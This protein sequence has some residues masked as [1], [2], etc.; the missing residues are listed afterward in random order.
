LILFLP[1]LTL[2]QSEESTNGRLGIKTSIHASLLTGT[3]LQNERP[4]FGYTAGAFYQYAINNKLGLHSEIVASF[5]GSNFK[6]DITDYSKVALFYLDVPILLSYK[7]G[8]DAKNQLAFGPYTSYLGLSSLYVG[9]QKKAEINDLDLKPI[10]FGTALYY[11][12]INKVTIFQV[13]VKIGL[14]NINNGLYIENITPPTGNNGS[15][16]NLSFEIGYLF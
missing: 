6:N 16:R 3:E 15:I 8:A 7:S 1:R 11:H 10:D 13:G 9:S 4:K 14:L 2:G 12:K 5:K